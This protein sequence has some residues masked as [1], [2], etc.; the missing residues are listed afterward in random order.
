MLLV[1]FWLIKGVLGFGFYQE[2]R[3]S[4]GPWVTENA[5]EVLVVICCFEDTVVDPTG[6]LERAKQAFMQYAG[7]E[8]AEN[9]NLSFAVLERVRNEV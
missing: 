9:R 2:Y 6:L 5:K 1:F 4:T 8:Q 7:V 3:V